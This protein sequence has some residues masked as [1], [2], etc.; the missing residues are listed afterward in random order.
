M[1]D[2]EEAKINFLT[3][4]LSEGEGDQKAKQSKIKYLTGISWAA[5]EIVRNLV[6]SAV[7]HAEDFE[8]MG[9]WGDWPDYE[10]GSGDEMWG[11]LDELDEQLYRQRSN[12]NK[13]DQ[14]SRPKQS[15]Q[16]QPKVKA[17]KR[18]KVAKVNVMVGQKTLD[19]FGF[20]LCRKSVSEKK[21]EPVSI[22]EEEFFDN[23]YCLE[24]QFR[25]HRV[26]MLKK[27]FLENAKSSQDELSCDKIE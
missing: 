8:L 27:T 10:G 25:L 22:V 4:D 23:E 16:K 7:Q 18:G 19:V 9:G 17:K 15:G 6:R 5:Y 12:Q 13:N 2:A 14:K 1:G 21:S 24:K 20:S 26:K 3:A 11:V